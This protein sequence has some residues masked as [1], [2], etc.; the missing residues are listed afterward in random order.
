MASDIPYPPWEFYSPATSKN[1][2][3]FD[4]DLSQALGKKIG[5]PSSFNK[6]TF[7]V[8]ILS[9]K[10][11]KNDMIHVGHVRQRGPRE[12]G[13]QLRRLRRG[14]HVDP[15]PEGQSKGIGNL[16]TLAGKTVACESG[17]TQQALPAE[18]EQDVRERRQAEDDRSWPFPTSRLRSW[19]SRAAGP[20]ATS[21]TTPPP[22][23]SPRPPPT[24]TA[25]RSWS[26]RRR[27]TATTPQ[28]VGIG[29]VASRTPQLLDTVQKALQALI[30]DGTYQ[31]IVATA[32]CCRSQSAADQPGPAIAAS[33]RKPVETSPKTMTAWNRQQ[34]AGGA[35]GRTTGR[36][37]PRPEAIKAIP[38]RH[39]GRWI[40]SVII[41]TFA[42]L[43]YSF[44]KNPNVEWTTVWRLAVQ[45]AGAAGSVL[46]LELTFI[47][48]VDRRGRR[49]AAGGHA[50][51]EELRLSSDRLGLH[52][53]LPGHAGLRAD[54]PV[55]QLRRPLSDASSWACRS[56]ASSFG[57]V[58][59]DQL[60][61]AHH[62]GRHPR[63]RA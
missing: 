32:A 56:P 27:P 13:R 29:I 46:T 35:A 60:V 19:P 43:I 44:V 38:V 11:G 59:S 23:T 24:A 4:Y 39:W 16:D 26:T 48:M 33:Q 6:V 50:A 12:A 18:P 37:P 41:L 34:L 20:S 14:R 7:D 8:I 63:A 21:P 51:V 52:L 1:P 47:A 54:P 2:A 15:G 5:I 55:G 30:D 42:A 22:R 40:A 36:R 31:N 3:G 57:S 28:L 45:A 58:D 62:R 10:G 17:T 61:S 53:V 49:D 9:I 25:S